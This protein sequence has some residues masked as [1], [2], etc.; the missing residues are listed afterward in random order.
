MYIGLHSS[1][2]SFLLPPIGTYFVPNKSK[3]GER[4]KNRET[5]NWLSEGFEK[6]IHAGGDSSRW[7]YGRILNSPPPTDTTNIQLHIK[8][9]LL[10]RNLEIAEFLL[11]N[12]L[13]KGHI[14]TG[15]ILQDWEREL[16]LHNTLKQTQKIKQNEE[17]EGTK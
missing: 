2:Y 4:E 6:K 8:Q 17:T 3:Y 12:Q 11:P 7:W 16:F 1:H 5:E 14:K 15:A 13:Q 9:F 10:K